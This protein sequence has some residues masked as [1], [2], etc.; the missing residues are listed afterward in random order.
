VQFAND[1]LAAF[2]HVEVG[3]G[4]VPHEPD[5][6]IRLQPAEQRQAEQIVEPTAI[7]AGDGDLDQL[8]EPLERA[9]PQFDVRLNTS[10]RSARQRA[11]LYHLCQGL[12]R[13]RSASA[14]RS[15]GA[16]EP[17]VGLSL[18]SVLPTALSFPTVVTQ[19]PS[20]W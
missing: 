6:R 8:Q 3:P 10:T 11:D 19:M 5:A 17:I 16:R 7:D 20:R 12:K 13:R 15:T 18:V 14:L 1:I 2:E 9:V 4:P